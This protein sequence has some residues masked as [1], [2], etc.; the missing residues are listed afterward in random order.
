M[1]ENSTP[2]QDEGQDVAAHVRMSHEAREAD[3]ARI[4]RTYPVD[5]E[6]DV[7]GH[8]RVP[9]DGEDDFLARRAT[10]DEGEDDVEAHLRR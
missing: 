6:D 4:G 1:S 5:G 7:E 8:V 3:D 9:L 2:G 10:P